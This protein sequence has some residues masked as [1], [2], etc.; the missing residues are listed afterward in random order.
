MA[1]SNQVRINEL[2]RELEIKAKV[3][4]EYL[5][6]AGVT[7]KKTHSSSIDLVHAE[8]VRKH[9][10]DMAAAEEAAEAE[11]TAKTT[12]AKK[13]APKPAAAPMAAPAT[14]TPAVAKPAA[15]VSTTAPASV[16]RPGVAAHCGHYDA[17]SASGCADSSS[18][19]RSYRCNSCSC[20][21][22][23]RWYGAATRGRC[24]DRLIRYDADIAA[25][26]SAQHIHAASWATAAP[27]WMRLR[28]RKGTH[29]LHR[30]PLGPA[31]APEHRKACARRV[32]RSPIVQQAHRKVAPVVP[33]AK[34]V[35]PAVRR[36]VFRNAQVLAAPAVATTKLPWAVSAQ[37]LACRKPSPANRCMRA[38]LQRVAAVRLSRNVTPKV[39]ANSIPCVHDR[40]LVRA[41]EQRPFNRPK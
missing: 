18:R 9:F 5:P 21:R 27:G 29:P 19:T 41:A 10:R 11:K 36:P 31:N 32:P 16:P 25:Y 28:L 23:A 17:S 40:V 34:V 26:G 38:S 3:L 2:A 8:R 24:S 39:N 7:E 15:P 37:V 12:A 30:G 14:A 4:I 1:D 35:G 22:I 6:E 33:P 20:C 13:P